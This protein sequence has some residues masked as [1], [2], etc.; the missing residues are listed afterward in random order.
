MTTPR[1]WFVGRDDA[2]DIPDHADS[3]LALIDNGCVNDRT[4]ARLIE[5]GDAALIVRAVNNYD[6]LVE[7]ARA[8]KDAVQHLDMCRMC[9]EGDCEEGKVLVAIFNAALSKL[10]KEVIE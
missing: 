2:Y 3:G 8:A 7:V 4:V 9:G 10:P 1:P 6:A 5:H